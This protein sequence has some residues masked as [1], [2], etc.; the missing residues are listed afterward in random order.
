[1]EI[2]I[3]SAVL[4]IAFGAGF[5]LMWLRLRELTDEVARLRV[6]IE[7][8]Q[9]TRA[10]K[11]AAASARQKQQAMFASVADV[12]AH[13]APETPRSIE[14]WMRNADVANAPAARRVER[15][16]VAD[17]EDDVSWR[18]AGMPPDTVRAFIAALAIASPAIGFILA[19]PVLPVVLAG[20]A[21][22]AL[23]VL[24]AL[25]LKWRAPAWAAA[26]GAGAWA[27]TGLQSGAAASNAV[28]FS[29]AL[30]AVAAAGF[31]QTVMLKR[32][33][34]G[35][36]MALF[37]AAA[38]LAF[39]A[40]NALIGPAG[41]A[42]GAIV[43]VGA[44]IGAAYL[45]R[46]RLHFIAFAAAGLGMLVLSGQRDAAIWFTPA[47]A[48]AGALFL[49]LAAVRAPA[50]GARG[51]L[52]ATTGM[53]A[54]LFAGGSLYASQSGLADPRAA[55]S[56]FAVL[57][58]LFAGILALAVRRAGAVGALAMTAW[59]L[60]A[61]IALAASAAI[62][63]ALPP[64]F[65]AAMLSAL[66]LALTGADQRWPDNVW[67]FFTVCAGVAACVTGL[68]AAREIG[69]TP[70]IGG[71][72]GTAMLALGIPAM[73]LGLAARAKAGPVTGGLLE[74]AAI[75]A[76]LAFASVCVRIFFSNGAPALQP[77]SFIEASTHMMLWLAA[78]LLLAWRAE[79][80]SAD[81][82]RAFALLLAAVVLIA[83]PVAA[84]LWFTPYWNGRAEIA[85][86]WPVLQHEPLGFLLVA[87]IAWSH[88]IYWRD[89]Q[90]PLR[91]RTALVAASGLTAAFASFEIV[92]A[93][94]PSAGVDWVTIG[95]SGVAFLAAVAINFAPGFVPKAAPATQLD[96]EE[97]LKRNG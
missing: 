62:V 69:L 12:Q 75:T 41:L 68:A 61:A 85:L 3:T 50:L 53:A 80:G 2:V 84:A 82:R 93:R 26:L 57:T 38:A 56:A 72:Y 35:A 22:A 14:S 52:V 49:G 19:W 45:R 16:L 65:Q 32:V 64:P 7:T 33:W 40:F 78:S 60:V 36:A 29:G 96:L 89:M 8:L 71:G 10:P 37:M 18:R 5:A 86:D 4:L 73:I 48:W 51:A 43:A 83:M 1:M 55:A 39:G 87:A 76:A 92:F 11:R 59:V 13:G 81:V 77:V 91:A 95:W 54:A 94:E 70:H 27:L 31:A 34:S 74:T 24:A 25:H 90:A 30:F 20:L 79:N 88:W 44:A 6:A 21:L 47:A 46:D 9:D 23:T 42:F 17:L 63:I 66:A 58:L 28:L 15:P 67:R 97:Y